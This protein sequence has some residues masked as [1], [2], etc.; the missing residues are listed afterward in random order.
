LGRAAFVCALA[1]GALIPTAASADTT[2]FSVDRAESNPIISAGAGTPVVVSPVFGGPLAPGGPF[3]LPIDGTNQHSPGA[4]PSLVVHTTFNPADPVTQVT[5][6]LPPGQ[7]GNP[8]AVPLCTAPAP[9]PPAAINCQADTFPNGG[10][11]TP[12][13][14]TTQVGTTT[15]VVAT[16]P[17]STATLQGKIYNYDPALTDIPTAPAALAIDVDATALGAGHI[18]QLVPLTLRPRGNGD[19]GL[20]STLHFNP[21]V[22]TISATLTLRGVVDRDGFTGLPGAGAFPALPFVINPTSCVTATNTLDS[23]FNSGATDNDS[24]A[25]TPANPAVQRAQCDQYPFDGQQGPQSQAGD[26]AQTTV[27]HNAKVS[28][29]DDGRTETPDDYQFRFFVPTTHG[30]PYQSHIKEIQDNLPDG[31]VLGTSIATRPGFTACTDAQ[32]DEGGAESASCPSGSLVGDLTALTPLL[33]GNRATP[34]NPLALA[35]GCTGTPGSED[36]CA[37]IEAAGL[38][39]IGGDVWAG[40]QVPGHPNQF[41]VFTELTDGGV[42][43]IK[44]AGIATADLQ[45][46]RITAVFDDLPQTPFFHLEQRFFGGDTG[47]LVNPDT[48]GEHNSLAELTQ[49]TNVLDGGGLSATGLPKADKDDRITTSFDGNGAACPAQKPFEPKLSLIGDPTTAGQDTHLIT[50]INLDDRSQN[51]TDNSVSLPDGLV[52]ALGSVPMC[53]R[54]DARAGSCPAASKIGAVETVVGNGGS[55]LHTVGSVYL[56]QPDNGDEVARITNVV[57]AKVGPFDLGTIVNELAIKLRVNGGN[58]GIDNVGIDKLPTILSGIP[59]RFR[60]IDLNI[61]RDG[62]LRNPLTCD[63]KN[64]V[65]TF[66]A[67][68]GRS[69]TSTTPFTATGCD[70]LA[71]H[72]QIGATIGSASQPIAV[73]GHPPVSTVVTQPDHEAAI[74]KSVV[75]LPQGL[76]PNVAALSTLCSAAQLSANT[77]PTA[78]KVGSAKAISPLIPDPLAGPVYLVENPGGL[79]K[80][81]IRL[82]GLLSLDLT[83]QTAL[84]GG[85]LVTTLSG[86]PAT[87]VSRFELN[88]D[89]GS[90]GLFT[91]SDSLCAGR[92]IDA[93]FDSHTGQHSTDSAAAQLVGKCTATAASS[94]RPLLSVR[95]SR[96]GKTPLLTVRA[97][98]ASTGSVNLSTLRLTIPKRFVVVSK[99][100]KKGVRVTA[101]GKK[102]NSKKFSLSRSGVLTVRGLP[103]IGRSNITVTIRGGALRTGKTLRGLARR[104]KA[105]PRLSFI[106]R[107]VD[108]KSKRFN[109]TVRVR[110]SR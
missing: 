47:L 11:G 66:G 65:G 82:G 78:S 39:P 79:P 105:L 100:I 46:G 86:L 41:K 29:D 91:V 90:R 13:N 56:S 75:T 54:S 8:Y 24:F 3:A 74:Q 57:P 80:L 32:F 106:G 53:S 58:I 85:R 55:P 81:V 12:A 1:L 63:T 102:L 95:V 68:D 109:Y 18:V 101:G 44:S 15:L 88:I 42:T 40:E 37:N 19:Y 45:T 20:D 64:G 61:N 52:G 93:A 6:H 33:D 2:A 9:T 72:P 62:F 49:W 59:I 67:N 16:G 4:F 17:A 104:K 14:P 23:V 69:A 38:D 84:Q 60:Q 92:N 99:R 89:G 94:R 34:V 35:G 71:F 10:G 83:G 108:V 28:S 103:K 21:A 50:R 26:I 7:L 48:C 107:V 36:P 97:R 5:L 31:T 25:F 98:K 27:S 76:N 110:P 51:L 73:D 96:V 22:P 70:T 87:P 77:C 30:L 43:R